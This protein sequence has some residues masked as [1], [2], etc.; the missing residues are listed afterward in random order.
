MIDPSLHTAA[1]VLTLEQQ[2]PLTNASGCFFERSALPETTVYRAFTP[3]HLR[4]PFDTVEEGTPLLIVGFPLGFHDALHHMPV[5]RHAIVA[6]SFGLRFQGQVYFLAD[7]RT[8]WGASG[9]PVVMRIAESSAKLGDLPWMPLGAHS[10]RIDPDSRD[11]LLDE[12][13]GLNCA[14]YAD[15]VMTL[16]S[17]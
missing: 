14:W 1:R 12:A 13:R 3:D 15:I 4:S 2:R 7:A 17:D 16:T 11:L 9:S 8:H 6:S 5:V 10:A